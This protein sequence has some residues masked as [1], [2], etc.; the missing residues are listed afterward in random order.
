MEKVED[1]FI[2]FK[3]GDRVSFVASG[4]GQDTIGKAGR[5]TSLMEEA[6]HVQGASALP[7]TVQSVGEDKRGQDDVIMEKEH[8]EERKT[9]VLKR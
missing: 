2:L 3:A 1:G 4:G 5:V 6:Q 8:K 7:E 9:V